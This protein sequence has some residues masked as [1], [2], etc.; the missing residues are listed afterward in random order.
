M[1]ERKHK[2]TAVDEPTSHPLRLTLPGY[3]VDVDH[4]AAQLLEHLNHGALA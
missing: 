4:G 2:G 1:E 3:D